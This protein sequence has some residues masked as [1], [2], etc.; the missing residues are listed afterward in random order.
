MT[1]CGFHPSSDV[2]QECDILSV[3]HAEARLRRI[4]RMIIR[5]TRVKPNRGWEGYDHGR[6]ADNSEI[7]SGYDAAYNQQ[8]ANATLCLDDLTELEDG[9]ENVITRRRAKRTK[10]RA[11]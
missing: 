11:K 10:K 9:G 3:M 7:D 5:E 8:Y 2:D 1:S 6:D 4:V